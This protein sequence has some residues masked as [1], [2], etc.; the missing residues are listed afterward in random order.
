MCHIPHAS[1]LLHLPCIYICSNQSCYAS[2]VCCL[3]TEIHRDGYTVNATKYEAVAF[4]DDS[5]MTVGGGVYLLTIEV[6]PVTLNITD[7]VGFITNITKD[8]TMSPDIQGV[9][10]A[11]NNLVILRTV[12]PL[13]PGNYFFTVGLTLYSLTLTGTFTELVREVELRILPPARKFIGLRCAN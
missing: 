9:S 6:I 7:I 5:T 13:P 2:I 1:A 3:G 11:L 10:G 12:N 8:G 4:V